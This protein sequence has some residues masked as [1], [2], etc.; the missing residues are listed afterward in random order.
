PVVYRPEG[1]LE[2]WLKKDPIPRVEKYF[3]N[4]GVMTEEE[5]KK[6]NDDVDKM[7]EEAIDFAEKSPVPSLES[8]L[9]DVYSDIV[10]E[11]RVR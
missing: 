4:N 9:K 11:G 3:V 7:V 6:L 10:E 8:A 5:I 1:E 2:A